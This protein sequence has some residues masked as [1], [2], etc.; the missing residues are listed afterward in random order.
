MFENNNNQEQNNLNNETNYNNF[1]SPQ[2]INPNPFEEVNINN[3]YVQNPQNEIN[4]APPEEPSEPVQTF[5]PFTTFKDQIYPNNNTFQE[6]IPQNNLSTQILNQNI[7]PKQNKKTSKVQTI[8]IVVVALSISLFMILSLVFNIKF[9]HINGTSM[10]PTM[11]EKNWVLSTTKKEYQYGDI[12]A[13]YHNNIIMIKRVIAKEGDTIAIDENGNVYV[14]NNLIDEPYLSNKALGVPEITFPH[15]VH[16]DCYFVLGDNRGD[17]IDSRNIAI[18]DV[19]ETDIV[20]RVSYS[21]I[22][23]KHLS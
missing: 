22:P 18:K 1:P 19:K 5:N 4:P 13:F 2:P 3:N 9:L 7:Y 23:F 20:G 14:N 12:V 17:S 11:S 10:S 8:A 16:P 21:I 6:T 15:T